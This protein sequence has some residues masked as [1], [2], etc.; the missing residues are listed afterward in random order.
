MQTYKPALEIAGALSIT[1]SSAVC[2]T[3]FVG[4]AHIA[5]LVHLREIDG[6]IGAT[7]HVAH[8]NVKRDLLLEHVEQLVLI[9]IFHDITAGTDVDGVWCLSDETNINTV[10]IFLDAVGFSP[11][12]FIDGT[13]CTVRGTGLT[14]RANGCTVHHSK[15]NSKS[16]IGLDIRKKMTR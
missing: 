3:S 11:G 1:V 9:V 7:W 10:A 14:V 12:F 15:K 6:R 8:I 2:R 16:E 13:C 4:G 5:S